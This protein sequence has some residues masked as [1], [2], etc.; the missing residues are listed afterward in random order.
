MRAILLLL[1]AFSCSAPPQKSGWSQPSDKIKVLSTIAMIQDLVQ[2]VGGAEV[3]TLTLIKGELDPHSYQLVKGDDEKF[4]FADLVFYNGLGLEHGPSLH[5]MLHQNKKAIGL[6]DRLMA[7]YPERLLFV[8]GQRDP[9]IWMDISLWSDILPYIVDALSV[10]KPEKAEQFQAN[11]QRFK[12]EM[13][14]VHLEVLE[15]L[16]TIPPEK[17]YLVTSHDAFQYFVKAYFATDHDWE[18]RFAAPEGLAP[19]SQLSVADIQALIAHLGHYQIQVLFPESNVSKDSI[20]KIVAAGR[21]KGLQ[22]LRMALEP[23]YADAMGPPGS[24]GDTYLKM[25]RYDA[26]VIWKNLR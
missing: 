9:H 6:G 1:L 2:A 14:K 19:E 24:E 20:R 17:R 3:E 22:P 8:R 4:A 26:E 23:L 5:N 10:Q 12:K 11:A 16:H 15:Q 13:E 7:Q 25:V 21:E 18:A